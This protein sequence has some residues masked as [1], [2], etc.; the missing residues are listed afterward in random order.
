ML[1]QPKGDDYVVAT[2][3]AH[4]VR[5]LCERAF[6]HV[7]L[8]YRAHVEID[9]RYFRP[10]E[11]DHLLGDASKAARVLGWRPRTGFAELVTL[12]MESDL[13]L[14]EREKVAGAG[15]AI[16]QHGGS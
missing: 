16:S 7:G 8:D 9:P 2:G 15:P 10:T 3:E 1:Q 14:A 6:G 4:T 13:K 11:V 5:E 12:M